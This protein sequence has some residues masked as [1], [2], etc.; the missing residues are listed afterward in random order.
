M[1]RPFSKE[2]LEYL[3]AR[4]AEHFPPEGKLRVLSCAATEFSN[5]PIIQE[6][7]QALVEG[8][9]FTAESCGMGEEETQSYIKNKLLIHRRDTRMMA[10]ILPLAI[11]RQNQLDALEKL[12]NDK[13]NKSGDLKQQ[14]LDAIEQT[15]LQYPKRAGDIDFIKEQ[16]AESIGI[17]KRALNERLSK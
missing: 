8:W 4:G 1:D 9:R 6:H 15:K 7:E 17:K 16:A 2:E 10:P 11:G 14:A 13:R 5:Y 3:K 12:N